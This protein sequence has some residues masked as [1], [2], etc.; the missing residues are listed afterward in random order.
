[1]S[2]LCLLLQVCLDAGCHDHAETTQE[3]KWALHYSCRDGDTPSVIALL[4]ASTEGLGAKDWNQYAPL[5]LAVD[6]GH[7]ETV[8]ALLERGANPLSVT[9][10]K[11]PSSVVLAAARGYTAVYSALVAH[12]PPPDAYAALQIV[13]KATEYRY[14]AVCPEMFALKCSP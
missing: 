13:I 7:L 8:R 2:H 1:M 10:N 14:R 6:G 12:S 3:E 9:K 5:H 4:G 11:G